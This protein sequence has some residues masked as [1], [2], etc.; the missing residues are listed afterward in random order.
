MIGAV[1]SKYIVILVILLI[2][3]G[4]YYF[5][6]VEKRETVIMTPSQRPASSE[7]TVALQLF[8]ALQKAFAE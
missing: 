6:R 5:T 8:K 2:A 3:G 7:S 1:K 4:Y